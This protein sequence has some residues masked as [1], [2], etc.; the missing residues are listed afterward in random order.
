MGLYTSIARQGQAI[1]KE[2]MQM[3]E[4]PFAPNVLILTD[5]LQLIIDQLTEYLKEKTNIHV[6]DVV[7]DSEGVLRVS[8]ENHIDFLIIAGFL[9]NEKTYEVLYE[10]DKIQSN[11]LEV[12]W[13]MIDSLILDHGQTY[14]IRA[15]FDRR[16]PMEEF[17]GFL[18]KAYRDVLL[19]ADT[20]YTRPPIRDWRAGWDAILAPP[21]KKETLRQRVSNWLN[22]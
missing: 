6:L 14:H 8:R 21:K 20:K 12:H 1:E 16:L 4:K 7:N 15:R 22:S 3:T 17:V 2:E 5:R 9:R 19:S 18:E 13:A 10:L 11:Y